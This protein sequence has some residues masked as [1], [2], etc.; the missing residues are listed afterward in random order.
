MSGA[1]AMAA[2]LVIVPAVS[3]VTRHVPGMAY[4]EGFLEEMF[5]KREEKRVG[6][7]GLRPLPGFGAAPQKPLPQQKP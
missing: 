4:E 3:F 5:G 6:C 1:A 7:R 2:G